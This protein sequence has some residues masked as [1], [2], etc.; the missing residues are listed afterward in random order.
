MMDPL[1]ADDRRTGREASV[2]PPGTPSLAETFVDLLLE[3]HL[4]GAAT[5]VP[6]AP[7]RARG[8]RT[9]ARPWWPSRATRRVAAAAAVLLGGAAIVVAVG[10]EQ[11]RAAAPAVAPRPDA[12][13]PQ[14]PQDPQRDDARSM[15]AAAFFPLAPGNRWEYR[16]RL[17]EEERAVTVLAAAAAEVGG[18]RV[19]QLAEYG[20]GSGVSFSF[21]SV[22][23]DGVHRH[24]TAGQTD[25]PC[26]DDLGIAALELPSP[27]GAHHEWTIARL[28]GRRPRRGV[29]AGRVERPTAAES[30]VHRAE[31]RGVDEVVSAGGRE[32]RCV[33]V[34][35]RDADGGREEHVHY[36]RGVGVVRHTEGPPGA[37]ERVREL[38]VYRPAPAL[39][40]P[41]AVLAATIGEPSA[42]AEWLTFA[43]DEEPVWM[44]RSRFAVLPGG[45]A[46]KVWRV[47]GDRAVAFDPEELEDYRALAEDED[48]GPR[49]DGLF[50][51]RMTFAIVGLHLQLRTS[52]RGSTIERDGG[53]GIEVGPGAT[54]GWAAFTETE[55]DGRR[56]ARRI[57]VTTQGSRPASIEIR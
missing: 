54:R 51:Q 25:D 23:A 49:M 7:A 31:L 24:A 33:H 34:V 42:R 50:P 39:P 27:V 19:V 32:W 16:E 35:V 22:G 9:L 45:A 21:W 48:F 55:R 1:P 2:P 20:A 5:A 15:R 14:S 36:A 30:V 52:L 8:P 43:A 53:H 13:D 57:E 29:W 38:V 6:G 17:G 11:Q 10:L 41:G 47:F 56:H 3:E 46:P 26:F 12:Q 44:L 37:P 40:E 4:G 18:R 28:P